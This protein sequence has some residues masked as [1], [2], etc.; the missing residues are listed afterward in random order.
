MLKFF[1]LNV[2]ALL[3]PG[4]TLSFITPLVAKEFDILPDILHEP[5]VVSTFVGELVVAK[6][7]Y[8]NFPIMLPN[9]VS[10]VDLVEL[11]MLD[12]NIIFCMD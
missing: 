12:F 8:R 6:I 10:Y 7:V 4:P 9:R 2:Y 3:Y 1:S 11:D 5:F